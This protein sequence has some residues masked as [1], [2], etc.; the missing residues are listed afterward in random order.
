[1]GVLCKSRAEEEMK[2][3]ITK[4]KDAYKFHNGIS[5]TL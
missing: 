1:V 4:G 2:E 3:K 5:T